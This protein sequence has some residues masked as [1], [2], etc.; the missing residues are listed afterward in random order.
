MLNRG[1]KSCVVVLVVAGLLAVSPAGANAAIE[2]G[3]TFT[4]SG[5]AAACGNDRTWLEYPVPADGLIT[6]WSFLADANPPQLKFKLARPTTAASQYTVIAESDLK[7]PVANVRNTYSIQAPAKAG[8]LIGFYTATLNDCLRGISTGPTTFERNGEAALSVPASFAPTAVQL[9][10]SAAL[11]PDPETSITKHPKRKTRKT[12]AKFA[13][14]S[15]VP[16]SAFEC[17]L[18]GR[19]FV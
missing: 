4:P 18:D 13:F 11:E 6:S 19:P 15:S 1:K 3:Q 14:T 17:S 16:G 2:V 5:G 7:T 9:D 12:K 10:L 8:D